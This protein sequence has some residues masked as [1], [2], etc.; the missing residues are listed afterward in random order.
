MYG[1][2]NSRVFYWSNGYT[3]NILKATLFGV[4]FLFIPCP[5]CM[6]HQI[7][8]HYVA[9]RQTQEV[10]LSLIPMSRPEVYAAV[11]KRARPDA[12]VALGNLRASKRSPGSIAPRALTVT[13]PGDA[14]DTADT[15]QVHNIDP[16][17]IR[18]NLYGLGILC[19]DERTDI[20]ATMRRRLDELLGGSP[21][22]HLLTQAYRLAELA[23]LNVDLDVG[24]RKDGTKF[25]TADMALEAIEGMVE[26]KA[27]PPPSMVGFSGQ[28]LY[29]LYALRAAAGGSTKGHRTRLPKADKENQQAFKEATEG[30][31]KRCL[32]VSRRFIPDGYPATL[33]PDHS[34]KSPVQWFKNPDSRHPKTGDPIR[35]YRYAIDDHDREIRRYSLKELLKWRPVKGHSLPQRPPSYKDDYL[36]SLFSDEP[37]TKRRYTAKDGQAAIPMVRRL[38]DLERLALY[39]GSIPEG[40]RSLWALIVYNT[41]Q[42]A[43]IRSDCQGDKERAVSEAVKATVAFSDRHFDPPLPRVDIGQIAAKSR[44]DFKN[45]TLVKLLEVDYQ[46]AT[47]A[48]LQFIIPERLKAERETLKRSTSS[49]ARKETRNQEMI[50]A[51]RSGMTAKAVALK[52]GLSE[53]R[54]RVLKRGFKQGGHLD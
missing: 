6:F 20:D 47:R 41:F 51:F 49:T 50:D 11:F 3:L 13:R 39:R 26:S 38:E 7:V 48:G 18:W 21:P 31:I 53:S 44:R 8:I 30:I 15:L 12:L 45:R 23:A 9:P 22:K 1:I 37:N 43:F 24:T 28:G 36:A 10:T 29:I 40:K 27:L 54:V 46:E 34:S 32:R 14:S 4:V 35:Y 25:V 17:Y 2:R 33:N 5:I 42:D 52:Y 16:Q 19:P